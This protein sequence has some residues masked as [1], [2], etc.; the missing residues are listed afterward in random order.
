VLQTISVSEV[1]TIHFLLQSSPEY[2]I[3]ETEVL[4]TWHFSCFRELQCTG[5]RWHLYGEL[6]F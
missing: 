6:S 4:T 5:N 2:G 3:D 1:L